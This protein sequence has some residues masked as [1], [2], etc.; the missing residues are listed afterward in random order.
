M[1]DHVPVVLDVRAQC[2]QR[3]HQSRIP[4]IG[5]AERLYRALQI[6]NLAQRFV[7]LTMPQLPLQPL[8]LLTNRCTQD[9]LTL[10]QTF[11]LLAS[12]NLS[13]SWLRV[14]QLSLTFCSL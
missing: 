10:H 4:G 9:R 6:A 11:A 1:R 14:L 2:R 5:L 8:D 7:H 13:H 3:L 12:L